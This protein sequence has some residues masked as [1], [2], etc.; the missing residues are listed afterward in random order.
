MQTINRMIVSYLL[1]SFWQITVIAAVVLLCSMFLRRVPG[2]YKH[3]LWVVCLGTCVLVPAATVLTQ[4]REGPRFEARSAQVAGLAE[5][6]APPRRGGWSWLSFGSRNRP[7]QFGSALVDALAFLYLALLIFRGLRLGWVYRRTSRIRNRA[8]ERVLPPTL[9]R[10]AE[11]CRSLLAGPITLLCSDEIMSPATLGWSKPVLL[12]PSDFFT[13]EISEEDT[14][15]ALAH[16]VAHIRRQDFLLN[17]F[18]EAISVPL[19]FHPATRLIKARIAQTRELACDEMA[20]RLLPS[21]KHYAHSLLRIAQTVFAG[22]PPAKSNYAMGLFDTQVLEERIMN[23]LRMNK[24]VRGPSRTRTLAAFALVCVVSLLTSAF[25]LRVADANSTDSQRFVGTW[26]TKYKG[27]T[28]ITMKLQSRNGALVGTCNHVD[29]V[30]DVDGELI[31]SSDQFV[32]QD[33]VQTK[34]SGNKL[35]LWIG[36]HD[37]IHVEFTLKSANEADVMMVGD[38]PNGGP[39]QA[40]LPK[41]PWHFQRVA[42]GR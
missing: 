41:K 12:V 29:R 22:A 10:A 42:E 13:G 8:Y 30:S 14:I 39:D 6:A 28:F 15:A 38:Q 31:P 17:V 19:C 33:I 3:N 37:S 18:Y 26:V 34:V 27:Q 36:G 16:E 9:A 5:H 40:P 11:R 35:E 20:A 32:D 23:I 21:G 24:D 1:N 25:S 4:V 2:R 7:V